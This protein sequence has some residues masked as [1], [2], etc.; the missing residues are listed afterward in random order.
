MLKIDFLKPGNP[1]QCILDFGKV[2]GEKGV[3]F[4]GFITLIRKSENAMPEIVLDS[5]TLKL[6]DGRV[7]KGEFTQTYQERYKIQNLPLKV[8][9]EYS[10]SGEPYLFYGTISKERK[11]IQGPLWAGEEHFLEARLLE[12]PPSSY[13]AAR[14]KNAIV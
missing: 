14:W 1:R 9:A 13:Q 8:G 11:E 5:G 6:P 4:E 3:S 10:W 7:L 12:A 2:S